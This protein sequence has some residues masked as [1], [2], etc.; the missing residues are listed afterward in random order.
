MYYKF[1]KKK[2]VVGNLNRFSYNTYPLKL[3]LPFTIVKLYTAY[4]YLFLYTQFLRNDARVFESQEGDVH[5]EEVLV[6]LEELCQKWVRIVYQQQN[7]SDTTV[8]ATNV[9]LYTFGSYRMCVHGP[10]VGQDV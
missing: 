2:V 4:Q 6:E 1:R 5:R 3:Q 9:K 7:F 8:L 10:G